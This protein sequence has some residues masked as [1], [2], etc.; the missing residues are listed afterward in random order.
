MLG[1]MLELGAAS[2]RLH[3]ELEEPITHAGVDRLWLAGPQIGALA[4]QMDRSCL[5]GHFGSAESLLAPLLAD[6]RAGDV[7]MIKASNGLKFAALVDAIR[8]RFA[9]QAAGRVAS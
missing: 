2:Q 8:E 4:E 9:Q 1:D 3:Q 7:I 5:A 6:I